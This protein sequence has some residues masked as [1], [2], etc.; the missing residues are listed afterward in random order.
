M[1]SGAE[2]RKLRT[3]LQRLPRPSDGALPQCLWDC[4]IERQHQVFERRFDGFERLL[5][6]D[7]NVFD[8][9]LQPD[10]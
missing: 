2:D 5:G 7:P 6:F 10:S 1:I 9:Y 3:V 4:G 8:L